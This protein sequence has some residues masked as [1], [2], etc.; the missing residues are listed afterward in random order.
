M[1]KDHETGAQGKFVEKTGQG[2]GGWAWLGVWDMGWKAVI[3]C[4]E[5]VQGRGEVGQGQCWAEGSIDRDLQGDRTELTEL[6]WE[7]PGWH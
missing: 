7:G 5:A 2:R 1:Q 4:A 3:R 6:R